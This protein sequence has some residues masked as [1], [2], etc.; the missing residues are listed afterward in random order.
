MSDMPPPVQPASAGEVF[1]LIRSGRAV[2]RAEV[3]RVTG[4]SRTAVSARLASLRALGL[5]GEGAA[6]ES[7]G[8]R[9]PVRLV[10]EKDAGVVLAA[11]IGRSRTQLAVCDLEGATLLDADFNQ[12]VGAGPDEV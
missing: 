8:G 3:G 5:V 10:F 11:A 6:T 7:G 2:T 4:L 12:E 1:E 9:P